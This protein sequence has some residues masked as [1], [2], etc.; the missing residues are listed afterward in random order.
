MKDNNLKPSCKYCPRNC[1]SSFC[2]T[3]SDWK[4]ALASLHWGE[5]PPISGKGG[6]G[7]LFFSGCNLR[8]PFCQNG[9]ISRGI[10]G[11]SLNDNQMIAIFKELQNSGAENLNFVTA[12]HFSAKVKSLILKA[13]EN[14]ITLPVVWNSSGYETEE[15]VVEL[16]DVVDIWLPDL[17]TIN[18]YVAKNIYYAENY[19]EVAI[20]AIAKMVE[21]A[22]LEYDK[23]GDFKSGVIVRHLVLPGFPDSSCDLIKWFSE[24]LKGRAF[25][26]LMSQFTPVL[27][28]GAIWPK[29]MEKRTV[30]ES[31]Y[32]LVLNELENEGIE[33]GF[34][35]GYDPGG[36]WL[37]DFAKDNPFSSELSRI[38]WK[39]GQFI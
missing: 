29:D 36:E 14:G 37:P 33:E 3:N 35:Q 19:A 1:K 12:T 17:K 20:K 6:S 31:E 32:N 15:M 5:E 10:I 2:A 26:S 4:L 11:N 7:T 34:F 18:P 38:I 8:C 23:N 25:L 39:E 13:R 16:S 24:N 22:P 28:D 30:S 21:L 27:A 9:Q